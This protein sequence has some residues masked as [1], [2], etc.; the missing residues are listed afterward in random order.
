VRIEEIPAQHTQASST[1]AARSRVAANRASSV[2]KVQSIAREPDELL[3]REA[4]THAG[5]SA[6]N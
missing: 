6:H 3:G 1:I 5:I 4:A 2:G